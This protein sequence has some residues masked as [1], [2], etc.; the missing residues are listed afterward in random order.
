MNK[1]KVFQAL[2]ATILTVNSQCLYNST[3][4]VF[5]RTEQRTHLCLYMESD[6]RYRFAF[7]CANSHSEYKQ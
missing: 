5:A 2:C 3:R 1:Y 6:I 7:A 4:H